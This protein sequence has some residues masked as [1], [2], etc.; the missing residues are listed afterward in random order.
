MLKKALAAGGK[1]PREATDHGFMYTRS[2]EDLDGH[3]WEILW[4]DPK[5]IK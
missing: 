4:M 3:T 1:E 2:V 5:A